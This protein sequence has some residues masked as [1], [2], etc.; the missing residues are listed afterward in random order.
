[1]EQKKIGAFIA[2]RR[3]ELGMTQKDLADKLGITDRA[4]SKWET[5]RSMPDLSLL[6]PLSMILRVRVNDLLSGV[7]IEEEQY[8]EKSEHNLMSIRDLAELNYL[9]AIR[10]G[11]FGM[12]TVTALLI[13]YCCVHGVDAVGYG[14][15]GLLFVFSAI[16]YFFRYRMN[17]GRTLYLYAIPAAV[18]GIANVIAFIVGTW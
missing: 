2:E 13:I 1:M 8:R 15:A 7:I 14:F 3:K 11:L 12:L 16:V 18:A 10:A 17:G 9:K 4:V 5:G 6:Q